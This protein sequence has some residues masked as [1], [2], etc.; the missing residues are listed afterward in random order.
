MLATDV[1]LVCKILLGYEEA[2]W[3]KK[4]KIHKSWAV[5]IKRTSDFGSFL[6]LLLYF[7]LETF[8]DDLR[9]KVLSLRDRHSR[10]ERNSTLY[11]GPPSQ[12][13]RR[14][15][16]QLASHFQAVAAVFTSSI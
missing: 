4:L 1:L 3:S 7:I 5:K 8:G 6:E 12:Q 16:S 13:A 15:S 11:A 2:L 14:L 9:S 10:T